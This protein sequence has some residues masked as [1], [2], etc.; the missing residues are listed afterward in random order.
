MRVLNVSSDLGLSMD[1]SSVEG[2][3]D[4]LAVDSNTSDVIGSNVND[5]NTSENGSFLIP[6]LLI[7]YHPFL[8]LPQTIQV[9]NLLHYPH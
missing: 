6:I 3:D 2:I 4:N 8:T 1:N 7:F 5:L 9:I